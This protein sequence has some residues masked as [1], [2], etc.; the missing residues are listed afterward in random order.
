MEAVFWGNE[1][2]PKLS[3]CCQKPNPLSL[4]AALK[5]HNSKT[6]EQPL[7]KENR[8]D[9]VMW[10]TGKQSTINSN[11]IISSLPFLDSFEIEA[12][13]KALPA[14]VDDAPIFTTIMLLN[15]CQASLEPS[16]FANS[17]SSRLWLHSGL[18]HFHIRCKIH[19]SYDLEK[20]QNRAQCH[21]SQTI[22]L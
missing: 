10:S 14:F 21:L 7:Q 6:S 12:R 1:E 4:K 16:V 11:H 9:Y 2:W 15:A 19:W 3:G 20:F 22:S 5:W 13:E 18:Y 8:Y 17:L